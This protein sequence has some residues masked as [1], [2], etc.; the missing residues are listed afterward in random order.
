MNARHVLRPLT[1]AASALAL[2]GAGAGIADARAPHPPEHGPSV[3]WHDVPTGSTARLRGLAPVSRSVAWVSGTG[4]EVLRTDDGGRSWDDVSP[5]GDTSGLEFRDIEAFDSHRA[6]ILSIGA[7]GDSRIY[8]TSDGGT[9]WHRTFTNTEPTAFYDCMSFWDTEHGLALSDPVDGRF[10]VISTDNGGRSWAVVDPAGMPAAL[11]GEFGFAA[12]G[13]CLVTAGG[14]DAWIASGGGASARV[15]RSHDRGRT[16]SVSSTPVASSAAGGI[17]SLAVRG[18]HRLVAVGG[19]YTN[20]TAGAR[21]S[22]F[23]RDGGRSWTAGGALGGYRSGAA[24]L[25]RS[26][27]AVIAVGPTGTDLTRDGGR[28][29]SPVDTGSLDA[30]ACT[31]DGACWASGEKGRVAVLRLR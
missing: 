25:P 23:S 14:H 18:S 27:S 2:T 1:V 7:G 22:A 8:R 21:A 5:G 24:F 3:S 29:W 13:T 16:W 26:P 10:R 6:V 4:G 28:T 12:S 11:P 15:F 17:F 20:P 31:R 19:D 9:T 30:V